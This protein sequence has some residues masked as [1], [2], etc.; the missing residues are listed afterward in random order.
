AADLARQLPT[1]NP[2]QLGTEQKLIAGEHL[3]RLLKSRI[4][5]HHSGLSYATRAGIIEPLAKAGQLRVVVAT[6][7]LAAGINFSLRSVSLA[8]ESYRRDNIE[9]LLRPDEI[10]QMF[11]RAG[12][13]GLDETGFVLISANELRLLDARPAHLSRSGAVDWSALLN[14]MAVAAQ[15]DRNPFREAVQVQERLFTTKPIFLGVEES[16]RHPDVPCGLKTD[17]E[18]ARHV[19]KRFREILNSHGEWEPAR[20]LVSRPLRE[21][22]APSD[23]ALRNAFSAA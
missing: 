9:Q 7:G 20:D 15:N 6:M 5:Y 13:R 3:G 17:A 14:I 2:L 11:G 22:V 16:L 18:R 4:A 8:A 12:R 21:I 19:R 10:L 1:P 23:D